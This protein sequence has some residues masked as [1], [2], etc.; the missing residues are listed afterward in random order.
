MKTLNYYKEV[1]KAGQAARSEI[2][3]I[4]Q[5][6]DA[7]C[8]D[9]RE[10][11]QADSITK[12]GY[13]TQRAMFDAEFSERITQEQQKIL[14]IAAEFER[15]SKEAARL[16][17]SRIDQN[18]LAILNSGIELTKEDW[19]E[20]AHGG[21][22]D[23]E[24]KTKAN[25]DFAINPMHRAE[26]FSRFASLISSSAAS[27]TSFDEFASQDDYW[28]DLA[29]KSIRDIKPAGNDDFSEVD[30]AFPVTYSTVQRPQVW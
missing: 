18:A 20:Q 6:Y 17:A 28:F 24:T 13:D 2:T 26:I 25:I 21:L 1:V 22:I 4:K 8:R 23:S 29:R 15:E 3:K 19:Q 14:D 10:E 16:D 12:K 9:L 30:T 5:A 7:A 27:G 11:L